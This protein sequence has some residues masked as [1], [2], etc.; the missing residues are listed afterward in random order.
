MTMKIAWLGVGHLARYCVPPLARHF[1]AGAVTLSPRGRETAAALARETG[2]AVAADNAALVEAADLIFLAPRPADAV[3]AVT[4]L[5]WRREQ[6]VVSLCAGLP[7]ASLAPAVAPARLVRAIPVLAALWGESPTPLYPAAPAAAEALAAWGPVVAVADE[8]AF[9]TAAAASVVYSWLVRLQADLAASLAA[10]GLPEETA[11]LL[12]AQTFRAA[13]TLGREDR[14]TPLPEIWQSLCS[15]GSYS[16]KGLE[17]LEAANALA[18]W[19]EAVRQ[20]LTL[21][22]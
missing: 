11:R 7:L 4:G 10:G 13:G 5:P 15:P 21:L 22:R 9:E 18:P 14:Q 12:M 17:Q 3:A 20:L 19:P 2:V 8:A 6:T 16:L 1:G